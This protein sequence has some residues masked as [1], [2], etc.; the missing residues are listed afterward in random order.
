MSADISNETRL[1]WRRRYSGPEF[2]REGFRPMFLAAGLWAALV[3][4]LWIAVWMG[5]ISYPGL[6]D[7]VTWHVHEMMFGY[8]G[9][10]LG[11]FVLTAVPNW[12]GRLPVRGFPLAA[13]A[14]AWIAGRV[15]IWWSGE[16]GAVPTAVLD[17]AYLGALA[18]FVG[19]EIVA[20]R[21]WRN[22]PV[23]AGLA[24]MVAANVLFHLA[25]M[26]VADVEGVGVRLSIAVMSLLLALIG[27]RIVPSFTRNWLAKRDGPKI[28]APMGRFD[29]VALAVTGVG[30]ATWVG[31]APEPVSGT[32]LTAAALL[33]LARLAR[34]RGWRTLAEPLLTVLHVGY[35]WLAI[36]LG[37]LGV[38][39]LGD[40]VPEKLALHVIA[41]GAI[42]TMTLAV[43]T[44]AILGHTGREL[45]AGP[46]IAAI[47]ALATV[48]VFTRAAY[49]IVPAM[50]LLWATAAAWFL[51][52]ALFTAVH[53][54]MVLGLRK[55]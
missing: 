18:I 14:L 23:L 39:R 38:S 44:R 13:L 45:H 22:L 11:G 42:A 48:P 2:L 50:S 24:L 7:P 10:T 3:V 46:W 30:L 34:W 53:A 6:F 26:E 19:N 51:A 9:A 47:Y 4:P 52:F 15:A 8:V 33:N 21:N 55:S 16:I 41:I 37:L 17:L 25:A 28:A 32:L 43:M 40:W 20:G 27:G 31:F 12:T 29:K 1:A 54:P 49:E 36:G 5:A 35:L